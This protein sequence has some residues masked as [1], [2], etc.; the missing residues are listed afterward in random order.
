VFAFVPRPQ[1]AE[2]V[3]QIGDWYFATK[4]QYY[5]HEC[6]KITL[7]EFWI[8]SSTRGNGS[9]VISKDYAMQQEFPLA[10]VPMPENIINFKKICLD[11]YSM[12]NSFSRNYDEYVLHFLQEFQR[13]SLFTHVHFIKNC[14][15]ASQLA[16]IVDLLPL[17][18]NIQSIEIESRYILAYLQYEYSAV[19]KSMFISARILNT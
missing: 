6:G 15:S 7:D 14:P 12:R 3:P 5:L 11:L 17:L 1:M 16:F 10:N 2:L 8:K 13:R 19:A 9:P 18:N 4:A